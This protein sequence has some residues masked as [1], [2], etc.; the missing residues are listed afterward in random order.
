M[1]NRIYSLAAL[2]VVLAACATSP[3]PSTSLEQA[4]QRVKSAQ[5]DSRVIAHAPLELKRAEQALQTAE[6]T[7][8]AEGSSAIV[9]HQSYLAGQRVMLAQETAAS[10]SDQ[11][12]TASAAAERDRMRLASRTSEAD[13]AKRQL[14]E[15]ERANVQKSSELA[16]AQALAERNQAQADRSQQEARQQQERVGN[17]EA[18]LAELSAKKTERGMVVTLGDVLFESGRSEL[19]AGADRQMLKLADA[20]RGDPAQLASIEGFTDSIGSAAANRELSA[21]RASAVMNALISLGV[22]AQHLRTASRGEDSPVASN[23]TAAGRQMNR[24]VEIVFTPASR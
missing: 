8:A 21:R 19:S 18:L 24:R 23:D 3:S 11:A 16:A 20:L 5:A 10:L 14:T 15:A 22:P 13:S 1:S 17:L 12:V 9:D 2:S 4:R 7:W 6:K